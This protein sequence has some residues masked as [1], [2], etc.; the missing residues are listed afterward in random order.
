MPGYTKLFNSILASTVWNEAHETRIVWITLLAM[1]DRDGRVEG[2]VPGLAVLARVTVD[3]ARQA[4]ARLCAPDP[5]SRSLEQEGRRIVPI[6]G[7]W[8]VVNHAKFRQHLST[9]ERREYQKLKQRGYR[10]TKR[11][12]LTSVNN[13][14]DKLTV[15]PVDTPSPSPSPSPKKKISERVRAPHLSSAEAPPAFLGFWAAYP[16][17]VGRAAALR[18][19]N[20]LHPV[21]QATIIL[22]QE[23]LAWQTQQDQWTKDNGQFIP[24]PATWLNQARWLDQPTT[25][26]RRGAKL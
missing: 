4:I 16:R 7:G 12:Q 18:A 8:L 10:A 2:S 20:K 21:S 23:A 11:G 24:H 5:D 19:W 3:E 15:D 6:D 26:L 1:T 17:K 14:S 22:M 25:T 9:D 13:V